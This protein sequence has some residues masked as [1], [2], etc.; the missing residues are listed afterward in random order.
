MICKHE[1]DLYIPETKA[2]KRVFIVLQITFITMI[3]EIVSGYLLGSVALLADGIH[4]ATHVLAFLIAYLAYYLARKWVKDK[5]FTFGTWKI[6]ILGAYTS[7]ILLFFTSF[8]ILREALSKLF[9]G[10]EVRYKE[11]LVVAFIG[12]VVNLLSAFILHEPEQKHDPNLWGAYLHVLADALTS[13]LAI[14]GLLAGKFLGLWYM[15][16]L[17]GLI[18]FLVIV[19]WSY[20]LVRETT[21][22]L[23]DREGFNP[24]SQQIIKEIEEDGRSRVYDIHL[25]RIGRNSYA[26][27]LGIEA[28]EDKGIEYYEKKLSKFEGIAHATL[29]LRVCVKG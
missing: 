15:D 5:S 26:C 25:L 7:G 4:M 22:I 12:L 13:V 1:H 20:N 24:L 16:P 29:E 17:L 19:R 11:A 6:E 9:T 21:P 3:L 18:G 14:V 2:S 27:I 28:T 10:G 8:M 23:L